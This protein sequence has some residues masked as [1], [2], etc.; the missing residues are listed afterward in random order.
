MSRTPIPAE[1]R[2]LVASRAEGPCEYW[3][4]H[5]ADTHFGCG[6]GIVGTEERERFTKVD[7]LARLA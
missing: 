6:E 1:L 4:I 3:L 5:E 7:R 2:R